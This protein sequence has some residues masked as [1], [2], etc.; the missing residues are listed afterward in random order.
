M[1]WSGQ[2]SYWKVKSGVGQVTPRIRQIC[3][4]KLPDSEPL[5]RLRLRHWQ[6]PRKD[7]TLSLAQNSS[8]HPVLGEEH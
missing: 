1:P 7:G 8:V 2:V 3:N 6:G 5:S 4:R